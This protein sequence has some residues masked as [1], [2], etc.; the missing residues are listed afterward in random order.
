MVVCQVYACMVVYQV[1]GSVPD[2]YIYGRL[3]RCTVVC[4][5]D[6]RLPSGGSI[7]WLKDGELL[8]AR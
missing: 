4:Q 5:V 1:N 2:V 6:P 7:T 8:S 3:A